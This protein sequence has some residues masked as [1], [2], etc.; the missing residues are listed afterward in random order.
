MLVTLSQMIR[1]GRFPFFVISSLQ[2]DGKTFCV[3]IK[4]DDAEYKPL[5]DLILS[6]HDE[7]VVDEVPRNHFERT[8][9]SLMKTIVQ[10]YK[11]DFYKFD[12]PRFRSKKKGTSFVWQVRQH[13]TFLCFEDDCR[14]TKEYFSNCCETFRDESCFYIGRVGKTKTLRILFDERS[15]K[16]WETAQDIVLFDSWNF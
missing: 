6:K 12:L 9:E 2:P 1:E 14:E 11:E 13:G 7:K 16:A 8:L 15:E 10:S 3:S 4:R 5:C